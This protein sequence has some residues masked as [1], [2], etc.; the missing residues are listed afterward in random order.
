MNRQVAKVQR[1]QRRP[2]AAGVLQRAIVVFNCA[3]LGR[4]FI[5][6]PDAGAGG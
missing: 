6:L 3:D 4:Q 1:I 5:R 2:H